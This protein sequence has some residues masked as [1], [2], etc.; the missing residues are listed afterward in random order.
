MFRMAPNQKELERLS[1]VEG[2]RPLSLTAGKELVCYGEYRSN[3][4]RGPVHIWAASLDNLQSWDPVWTFNSVRHV[5]GVFFDPFRR[6]FWVTTGDDDHESAIWVTEDNFQ[7]LS[8]VLGGTQQYR[9]I[10][11]LFTRDA[12][13]FGSDAPEELNYLYRLHRASG[14]VQRLVRVGSSVFHGCTVGDRLFFSTAIEPSTHNKT[15]YVEVWGSKGGEQWQVIRRFQK[16]CWPMKA[17][18]Y[19]Q[20]KFPAG[21][22]DNTHLWLTPLA[23]ENDQHTLKIPLGKLFENGS[24]RVAPVNAT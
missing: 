10:K 2:S 8:R 7:S 22:G 1:A 11:L 17:F 20:V 13:Y 21:Q 18:Q 9:T 16:D 24:S 5:H 23:T 6:A 12:V 19:G 3:P 15:R 14:E 4:E